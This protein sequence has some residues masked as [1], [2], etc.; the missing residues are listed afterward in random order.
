MCVDMCV[1]TLQSS[2][3]SR[4]PDAAECGKSHVPR[5]AHAPCPTGQG[6]QAHGVCTLEDM[7]HDVDRRG[8]G[9]WLTTVLAVASRMRGTLAGAN[10][11]TL[12]QTALDGRMQ[13]S[14]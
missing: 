4:V 13:A 1:D 12:P 6:E 10:R 2:I 9:S 11:M 8:L 3:L 14:G 7:K 5:R